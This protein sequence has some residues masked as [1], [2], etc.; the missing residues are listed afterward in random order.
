MKTITLNKT[1]KQVILPVL[2]TIFTAL[3]IIGLSTP[4]HATQYDLT[5]WN[6]SELNLSG[7]WVKVIFDSSTK[8]LSVRLQQV[9][10]PTPGVN[11]GI[12]MFAYNSL[13]TVAV[14]PTGWVCNGSGQMDGFGSFAQKETGAAAIDG[15]SSDLVFVLSND[16]PDFTTNTDEAYF[17]A[18][19][20]YGDDCSGFVSDASTGSIKSKTGCGTQVPEPTTFLLLG[21]GLLGLGL[22]GRRI[23]R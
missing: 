6:V 2:V 4:A 20:R 11:A 5:N 18:H 1:A 17:A 8:E 21:S 7:D 10:G 23:K 13:V 14:C 16:S 9:G 19:V 22:L 12:D 15:I 3:V